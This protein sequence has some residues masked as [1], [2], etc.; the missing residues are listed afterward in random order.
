[1]EAIL[2]VQGD[3]H[4]RDANLP[5]KHRIDPP[6]VRVT[7]RLGRQHF[8]RVVVQPESLNE[9]PGGMSGRQPARA[10]SRDRE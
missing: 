7:A 4:R 8:W 10:W 2:A 3:R 5:S 1:V 9:A 6:E